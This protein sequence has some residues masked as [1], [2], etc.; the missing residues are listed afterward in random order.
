MNG[1]VLLPR[2]DAN[3]FPVKLL[4]ALV[5]LLQSVA[6]TEAQTTFDG[7]VTDSATGQPIAGASVYWGSYYDTTDS[8]GFWFMSVSPFDCDTTETL[9]ITASCYTSYYGGWT[10]YCD[11][12]NEKNVT[13]TSTCDTTPPTV[14][15]ISPTPPYGTTFSSAQTVSIAVQ[16]MDNRAVTRVDFYLNGMLKNSDTSSPYNYSWQISATD[17]C[18]GSQVWTVYAYD[19][20]GNVGSASTVF[21]VQDSV[22]PSVSI[23]S[24]ANNTTFNNCSTTVPVTA[25][26]S[27]NCGIWYVYF[28]K[29]T[30]GVYVYQGS[31]LNSPPGSS[32]WIF[33]WPITSADNGTYFWR[34]TASDS[35]GNQTTSSSITVNVNLSTVAP[36][37]SINSPTNGTSY[38]I[39][40]TNT[41]TVTISA[42]ASDP[43]GV[44]QVV[45]YDGSTQMG[46][47]TSAPYNY[48]WTFNGSNG[49]VHA[50]TARAYDCVGNSAASSPVNLT[51]FASPMIVSQPTGQTVGVGSNATFNV[52][53]TGTTPLAYQWFFNG[54]SIAG[55]N[56]P[57]LNLSAV[58][59]S[60]SGNYM[61]VVTNVYG[62]ITSS[63]ANLS[64]VYFAV[65]VNR[66]YAGT[67]SDGSLQKPYKTV[68][69]GYQAAQNNNIITIFATNYPEAILMNK[70]LILQGTNGIV[71]I[72]IP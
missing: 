54:G 56:S 12:S 22:S 49:G 69:A 50:W 36:T 15:F 10:V 29:A 3:F 9:E 35:H 31:G 32:S 18:G 28:Y 70:P 19:A 16:A 40:S 21:Y 5:L 37:V 24:P 43:K 71:N 46:T 59:T 17:L 64:V 47:M 42:S 53:A 48:N 51:V 4:L 6:R 11:E 55:A 44:T 45:F 63:V 1:S 14:S 66:A 23:T 33:N 26:A 8:S 68:T 62:S 7:Y 34:A 52:T 41:R 25:T 57:S 27:D 61:V 38:I 58:D 72:G 20:A 60:K 67:N 2:G 39:T 65:Y 13:L 30:G